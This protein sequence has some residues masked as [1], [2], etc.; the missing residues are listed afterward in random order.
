MPTGQ[1]LSA[2]GR[3]TA[4]I[5]GFLITL[6]LTAAY[7]FSLV[8]REM[9]KAAGAA[10]THTTPDGFVVTVCYFGPPI[11]F[12]PR[13]FVLLAL[14]LACAGVLRGGAG[15]RLLS[16]LGVAGASAS[17]AYWWA[18]SYRAFKAYSGGGI[19]F[20]NHPEISQVAYLYQG[21]WLDVCLAVS[22]L[23]ALVL[24]AERL[25]KEGPALS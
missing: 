9:I 13:L 22:L 12:Y 5:G 18:A 20:L 21:S 17:Y 10:G 6:C 16:L 19:D 14:L 24:L 8:F 23:A 4:S 2:A 3:R 1:S 15:G 7:N 25:L 11:S